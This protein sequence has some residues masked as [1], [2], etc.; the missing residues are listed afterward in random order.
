MG[1]S[2]FSRDDYDA[3][4]TVRSS[5]A[6]A[7]G[8]SSFAA[9]FA[10]DHDI[11][12]GAV[13]AAVHP[14]LNPH[15]VNRVSHDSDAHP[16]TVPI[17]VIFDT[18]GS[19]QSVPGVVQGKLPRLMGCFL[20]DKTSGKRYLGDG[21]PA[22]LVG[23]VDDYDAMSRS[24]AAGDGSFQAGQFESGIEIDDNL[25][26]IW[27]TG[28]GG[29]TYSESY[30]LALYFAARHTEHDHWDKRGRKGYLFLI[31]DE[32]AYRVVS[33]NEVKAIFGDTLQADIP[34]A[35][36]IE[37][38]KKRYHVF[39]IIPGMTDHFNDPELEKYWVGLLGQQHTIKL[40]DPSK[41]CECIVAAVALCEEYVGVDD[42]SADLGLDG[43]LTRALVPLNKA[44]SGVD[45]Y[46][47]DNLP[48]VAGAASGVERL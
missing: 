21:Y 16:V 41:I 44:G 13:K 18:T 2:A 11:K 40:A 10:Y 36:I 5:V 15:G 17:Q 46:S 27:L 37:E 24:S 38:A 9:T 31:G 45:R 14:S 32:H 26:N 19:M 25:T 3:R 43:A 29:G 47:A 4:S 20:D 42:V 8:I 34:L 28:N 30:Q 35:D 12:T 48:V 22:I 6:A 33:Q 23:A 1:S 7:K 39:F